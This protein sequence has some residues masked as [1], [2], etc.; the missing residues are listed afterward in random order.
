MKENLAIYG[1]RMKQFWLARSAWQKGALITTIVMLLI[2]IAIIVALS[3]RANYAPLY[4][5]LTLAEAGQ[6]QEALETRGIVA[7]ISNN[8]T[9]IHVPEE[10]VDGLK[11]DLAAEGLPQSGSID[12][13]FFQEQMGFGMTDN[14]FSV[15]E[16]SL[17]QTELAELVRGVSGVTNANVMITLPEE[18]VWLNAEEESATAAVVLDLAP[19][20][21]LEE[22]Q[23]KALYHLI[24]KSVPN[25]SIENIVVSDSQFNDYT[26]TEDASSPSTSFES[27]REVKKEIEEDLRRN[28]QQLLG[29]VV[30][31]QNAIVSI[32]TDIDFTQEQRTEELVEPVNEEEMSGIAISAERIIDMY[33]GTGAEDG[34]IVGAGDEIP[35]FAG[36]GGAGDAESERTEERINYE[37]NRIN[38]EIIESPY[39]IRDVGI[40][41][42]INPPDGMQALP[43]Q[44]VGEIEEMLGTIISTTLPTEEGEELNIGE[45]VMVASS[46]FVTQPLE[47]EEE[48]AQIPVWLYVL[49]GL[50]LLAI[51]VISML[52]FK[53]RNREEPYLE[54]SEFPSSVEESVIEEL[55][56]NEE[57]EETQRIRQIDKL[58]R[59]NPED[60]S[61]LLRTWLSDE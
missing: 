23:V 4:S 54:Q 56:L 9:T 27:Q 34:G 33:E 20:H 13:S 31:P 45:K 30:G 10:Q 60:F 41:V 6:I 32:T 12:Y 50:L 25:L 1:D 52:L 57:S 22:V 47:G 14:E 35:N 58:A 42:M 51:A 40:Q 16:R 39:Q 18:S 7:E 26:Y 29:A 21:Q 36:A 49:G 17:M 15:I 2:S 24:S 5:N 8:G 46:S 53:A 3:M 44:Q 48:P 55:P 19:G 28:V 61:K 11:V 38:R 43:Q 37:V 59:D